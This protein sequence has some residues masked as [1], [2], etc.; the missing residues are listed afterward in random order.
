MLRNFPLSA[1]NII[2][3][4]IVM[5][6]L[7]LCSYHDF[8]LFHSLTEIFSFV[9]AFGIFFIAWNSRHIQKNHY[10]LFLG[11]AYLFVGCLDLAHTL[12]YKGMMVLHDQD[13][14]IPT[15]LWL[16]A[17]YV[18]S[19]SLLIAPLF[20]TRALNPVR[21]LTIYLIIT[22]A[23][24]WSVFTGIFP[25]SFI[26]GV[27]LT[28]FKVYSE[29]LICFILAGAFAMLWINRER[30][31]KGI[32]YL[33]GTSILMTMGAE[34]AFTLYTDVYGISN[35]VG[36][37]LKFISFYLIYKALVETGLKEPYELL[38]R[39]LRESE[40]KYRSLFTNMLNGFAY[41][42]ILLDSNGVPV[43]Y[44]FLEVNDAFEK[45]TGLRKEDVLGQKVTSV[46][47]GIENSGFDW[48]GE[49]GKVALEMTTLRTE[50]YAN[51][52]NRWYSVSAYSPEKGYFATIFEDITQRKQAEQELERSNRDLQQ[53]ADILSH[54]LREPLRTISSFVELLVNRYRD[55][56]DEKADQYMGFILDGTSHMQNMLQDM[57]SFAR[58]GGGQL[59]LRQFDLQTTL[60]KVLQN[61]DVTVSENRATIQSGR[62]PVVVADE[63][64]IMHLL[65]NLIANSIKFR[66]EPDP[67]LT[68]SAVRNNGEWIICVRDN[69]IGF[70][71]QYAERI[72]ILF[73]RLHRRGV[74][75]GTG[76]GLALCKKIVERHKGRIWA[77]SEPGQGS[78]FYFSLP[79]EKNT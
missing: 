64:Q 79:A 21:M 7:Y 35:I 73:Q 53:F 40:T 68:I 27:G 37:F 71:Q 75:E 58:L 34:L 76:I 45:M 13:A 36:H 15:Q 10:L 48:I 42:Q 17:R 62:L 30:F 18:E 57:L 41:H 3:L 70:D 25:I 43:D 28:P 5:L 52:L 65:Q 46:I 4:A 49:Y 16:I 8:L 47:P 63:L 54:D 38:F 67:E 14:N 59:R 20:L 2:G 50:Q 51:E 39:D 29:Y 9:I 32:F 12:F 24:V 78:S 1:T 56:L 19:I 69:G 44:V 72:F 66:G 55:R 6:A 11:I 31:N 33:L 61:M 26:D 23:M 22:A 60:D 74:Y 77:E